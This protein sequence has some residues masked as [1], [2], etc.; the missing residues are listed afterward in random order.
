MVL[1]STLFWCAATIATPAAGLAANDDDA[2]AAP[3]LAA[4]SVTPTADAAS[5]LDFADHLFAD[6]DWYR[7]ITEYRRYL[8]QVRGT[9]SH[10]PRAALAI[11]EALL[12]GEQW[13]AAGRQLDGVAQRTADLDL[14]RAALFGA[15]RAYLLDGRAELAKPRFRLLADD[16]GAP[17]SMRAEAAWL[18][19]WGHFDAGELDDARGLFATIGEGSS[20]R[21]DAAQ[22]MVRALDSRNNLPTKNPVFAATFAMIP[23]LGHIYL[24]EWMVGLA[25][26]GWNA[27]FIFGAAAAWIQGLWGP[28]VILTLFEVG[29]YAGGIFGAVSGAFRHNRDV[30]RNWRDQLLAEYG[31]GRELPELYVLRDAGFALPGTPSR[32]GFG[33]P[34][35]QPATDPATIPAE[36]APDDAD[37]VPSGEPPARDDATSG[38]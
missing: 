26:F 27:L 37:N 11:G 10:A 14:R 36:T 5:T 2:A 29:W 31:G 28:A 17:E 9:G 18:L 35:M 8:Y 20:E 23:G 33:L 30:V 13:D 6:G 34:V 21:R 22:A 38:T 25:S 7:A 19:A 24:G 15:G 12:R 3:R 1:V 32:F 16:A 4:A